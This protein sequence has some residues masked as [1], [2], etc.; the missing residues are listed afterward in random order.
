MR[1]RT[2]LGSLVLLKGVTSYEAQLGRYWIMILR[3]RCW[4]RRMTLVRVGVQE[5]EA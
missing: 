3:P 1:L 2:C 5:G 4:N